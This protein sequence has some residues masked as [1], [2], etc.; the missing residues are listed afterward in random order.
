LADDEE[1]VHVVD[2][3]VDAR[4]SLARLLRSAGYAVET[5]A[6]AAELL[7]Q[8]LN[9]HAGCIL[10]DVSMPGLDGMQ[11]QAEMNAQGVD[12]PVVFLTG[13]GDIPMSVRAMKEGAVDFLTKV[14][15]EEVL[16]EAVQQALL[17]HRSRRAERREIAAIRA[18]TDSLTSREQEVLRYVI[19]G[20]RNKQIAYR[21]GIAEQTVKIHRG[22]VMAKLG[23]N[24]VTA[25]IQVC[26]RAG[27]EPQTGL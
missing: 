9:Q 5:F 17:L 11:L 20:A 19:A 12:L 25:L 26:Q 18:R 7:A 4:K 16:L 15:D 24:T 3:D 10:L 13:H 8:D 23:V 1:I 22:R 6:G 14:A 21:L 2:D 27:I